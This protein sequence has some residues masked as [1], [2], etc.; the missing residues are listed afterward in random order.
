MLLSSLLAGNQSTLCD[1]AYV[2]ELM[3]AGV[4]PTTRFRRMLVYIRICGCCSCAGG[5]HL[6]WRIICIEI[7]WN[8]RTNSGVEQKLPVQ[9]RVSR[10]W[11][12]R[13]GH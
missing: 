11:K 4:L 1:A 8:D 9:N 7:P 13:L 10:D 6:W 2:S 3:S 5:M 12:V